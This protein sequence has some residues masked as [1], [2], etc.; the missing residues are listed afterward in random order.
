MVTSKRQL[1]I[2][3]YQPN[4]PQEFRQIAA[5]LRRSLGDRAL[6]ID[7]IGSTAVPGLAAKDV[8]DVQISVASL[9]PAEPLIAGVTGAGYEQV[10]PIAW[11][12]VPS[13][14]SAAPEEWRKLFFNQRPGDR[15]TNV[16]LRVLGRANQRYPL[17]F[18]DYLRTHPLAAGSYAEIKSQLARYV[19]NNWDAYYDIKDPVCDIIIAAAEE[20]AT[21]TAWTLGPSDG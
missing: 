16:H 11:D 17:L 1:A 12:H 9:Q 13:G 4:W 3:T 10:V 21:T 14:P 15:P 18:R 6:R 8:I 19:P 5:A 20:W 7:H 2:V